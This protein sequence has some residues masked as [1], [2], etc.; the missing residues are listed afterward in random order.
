MHGIRPATE[1]D[2]PAIIQ[3]TRENRHL[4]ERLE[5]T[6]WRA[7]VNADDAHAA[8]MAFVVSSHDIITRVLDKDGPI[9]FSASSKHPAGRWFVDDVCL[10]GDAD[11]STDG[12]NLFNAIEE[13]PA[14]MTAPHQDEARVRAA[15]QAGLALV[16]SF[17]SIRFDQNLPVELLQEQIEP[18]KPPP[19]LIAPPLHVFGPAMTSESISVI[20]DGMDGHVVLSPPVNVPPVYDVGGKVSVIDRV[21]ADNRAYALKKALS[22]A[23]QREDVGVI[24]I[25]AEGDAELMGIADEFGASHPVDVF[26]WPA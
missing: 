6:F 17:R 1:K 10:S 16:S 3:L 19:T 26:T 8:F 7:S 14:V 9:A 24:L 22:Y 11:W 5:P 13:R 2:L 21:V 4:L 12:Q 15:E 18:R 23:A 20:G 25:V